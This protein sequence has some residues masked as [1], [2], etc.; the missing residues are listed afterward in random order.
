MALLPCVNRDV[1]VNLVSS[2]IV[3]FLL[4]VKALQQSNYPDLKTHFYV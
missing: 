1:L 4:I 3:L 2:G